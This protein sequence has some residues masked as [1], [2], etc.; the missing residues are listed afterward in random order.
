MLEKANALLQE[1]ESNRI[2]TIVALHEAAESEAQLD[3]RL[4]GTRVTAERRNG[5]AAAEA[6]R[7]AVAPPAPGPDGAATAQQLTPGVTSELQQAL[8]ER[9]RDGRLLPSGGGVFEVRDG[10]RLVSSERARHRFP[11]PGEIVRLLTG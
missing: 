10:E 4:S 6:E 8:P 3:L 9:V 7:P 5:A 1:I 11:E 2:Q